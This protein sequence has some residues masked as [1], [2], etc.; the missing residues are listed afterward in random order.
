MIAELFE[1]LHQPACNEACEKSAE[2]T[3]YG[4]AVSAGS[5]KGGADCSQRTADK[6]NQ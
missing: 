2:E 1:H 6:T 5:G 3:G 4:G